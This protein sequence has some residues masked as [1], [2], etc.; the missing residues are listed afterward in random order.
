[1]YGINLNM[2]TSSNSDV[3]WGKVQH[4]RLKS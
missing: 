1:L 3:P 4:S 2:T